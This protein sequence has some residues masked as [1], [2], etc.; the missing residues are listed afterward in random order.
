M[1]IDVAVRCRKPPDD[2][3]E[4]D[5]VV[6]HSLAV[7]VRPRVKLAVRYWSGKGGV[8]GRDCDETFGVPLIG[9]G[10]KGSLGAPRV[11]NV[12]EHHRARILH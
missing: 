10:W 3:D 9:F 1:K 8:L 4:K 12:V 7:R 11:G 5:I 2:D 6:Q